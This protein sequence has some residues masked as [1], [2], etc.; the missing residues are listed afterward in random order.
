M[1][2]CFLPWILIE[3]EAEILF[4]STNLTRYHVAHF[5]AL[6]FKQFSKCW[7][8]SVCRCKLTLLKF[9]IFGNSIYYCPIRRFLK[10]ESIFKLFFW[11]FSSFCYFQIM[12][13]RLFS[14]FRTSSRERASLGLSGFVLPA[15]SSD[16]GTDMLSPSLHSNAHASNNGKFHKITGSALHVLNVVFFNAILII[17]KNQEFFPVFAS[18]V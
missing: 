10:R 6:L 4:F 9:S 7:E 12:L 16:R 15:A 3:L 2:T 17:F 8:F 18:F 13:F 14:R 1:R 11:W 5:C